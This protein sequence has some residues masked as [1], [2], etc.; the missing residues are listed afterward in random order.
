MGYQRKGDMLYF[1]MYQIQ[2]NN[3]DLIRILPGIF[4]DLTFD[5]LEIVCKKETYF[6]HFP[7]QAA[8]NKKLVTYIGNFELPQGFVEP[9][10]FRVRTV[11]PRNGDSTWYLREENNNRMK[12]IEMLSEEIIGLSDWCIWNDTLL[13]ERIEENWSLQNWR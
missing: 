6:I 12:N 8:L 2:K 13:R 5:W 10:Y 11:N 3:C 7:L 1:N 4:Q 9:K